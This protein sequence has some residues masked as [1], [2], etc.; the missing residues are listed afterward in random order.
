MES[1]TRGIDAVLTV[2][3]VLLSYGFTISPHVPLTEAE[4]LTMRAAGKDLG[5]VAETDW[6]LKR[7]IF[8]AIDDTNKRKLNYSLDF[9]HLLRHD[10]LSNILLNNQ[11][12]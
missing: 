12:F 2:V 6:K 9:R 11:V 3:R 7:S 10:S 4:K 8:N 5:F 1:D